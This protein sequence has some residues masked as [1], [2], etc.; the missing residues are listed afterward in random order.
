MLFFHF[1]SSFSV[2]SLEMEWSQYNAMHITHHECVYMYSYK[3]FSV[4]S[5]PFQM[6]FLKDMMWIVF[7]FSCLS[8]TAT[9]FYVMQMTMKKKKKPKNHYYITSRHQAFWNSSNLL[10]IM[11]YYVHI[12]DSMS[13]HYSLNGFWA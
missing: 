4:F 1:S 7:K 9:M 11:P 6:E 12:L 5:S 2:R 10:H 3:Y 8:S 13:T